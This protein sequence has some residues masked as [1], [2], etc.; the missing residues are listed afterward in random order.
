MTI[1]EA[2][3]ELINTRRQKRD[4]LLAKGANPY[5][6]GFVPKDKAA[7]VNAAH[8]AET[9]EPKPV[10]KDKTYSLAGRVMF[11]R[12]FGKASFLKLQDQSGQIQIYCKKDVLPEAEFAAFQELDMGDIIYVE[13]HP[14]RTKTGELT[15]EAVKFVL[16]TKALRPLPDKWHGLTDHET[17]YRQRY[18]DLIVNEDV[19]KTFAKRAKM[20]SAIR[21]Y[22]EDADFMEVETPMLQPIYGGAAAKPFTTHHNALDLDLFLRIAP[23]LYLKR[24]VVGG[25]DRVFEINKNFRNEGLSLQHNPEFTSLEF[26][27]AYATYETLMDFSAAMLK[28]AAEVTTGAAK[29]KYQDEE[30]D[31]GTFHKMTVYDAIRQYAEPPEEI[32]GDRDA[33]YKWAE[34]RHVVGIK[35]G[36]PHGKI[37]MAAFEH[38]AEKKIRQPTFITDFP[39]EVSPLA[40]K[41]QSNPKLVDRFELYCVGRE[42]AN[43]FSELNDPDDQRERFLGQASERE[44]GDEEA[45][46]MDEDFIRALEHGMPPTAGMGI[47]I[48]RL[49]MLL[50]DASSIRDVIFFPL[51]RG[52]RPDATEALALKAE[53]VKE[54]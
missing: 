38:F 45:H 1:S 37:M 43:A 25:F 2:E 24:L 29:F 52:E 20:T 49:A 54:A 39:L 28:K 42:L 47:G 31:F 16:L 19:R 51:M 14:F 3:L 40:R 27:W 53:E 32:F 15:V 22:L 10:D 5:A 8:A 6:N 48:D 7:A 50:C 9:V 13:G 36:D 21:R 11:L 12:S 35:A 33:A 44:R 17:R 46:Q 30:I 18:V 26:Y 4:S 34:S 23:E 41:K